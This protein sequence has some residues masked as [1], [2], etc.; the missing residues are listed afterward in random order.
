LL[1]S[2]CL[3]YV[4]FHCFS[5]CERRQG[6]GRCLIPV[7]LFGGSKKCVCQLG[8]HRGIEYMLALKTTE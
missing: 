7:L 5:F 3:V 6:N 4:L 8:W 1:F 2:L